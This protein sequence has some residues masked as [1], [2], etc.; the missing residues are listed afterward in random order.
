M[1]RPKTLRPADFAVMTTMAS[2][3]PAPALAQ[4]GF[5]TIHLF[6]ALVCVSQIIDGDYLSAELDE[7]YP[8]SEAL[9]DRQWQELGLPIPPGLQRTPGE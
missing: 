3:T 5:C 8:A 4:A 6:E 2:S 9:I 7:I 1:A